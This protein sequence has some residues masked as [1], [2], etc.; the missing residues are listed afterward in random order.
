MTAI[1]ALRLKGKT[2]FL[3]DWRMPLGHGRLTMSYWYTNSQMP[4]A[5]RTELVSIS[6]AMLFTVMTCPLQSPKF[7][8]ERYSLS[9][10]TRSKLGSYLN[11]PLVQ[12]LLQ[13][14]SSITI[15]MS[16][17]RQCGLVIAFIRR[18]ISCH[19]VALLLVTLPSTK[20]TLSCWR[21]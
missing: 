5:R 14:I 12:S 15:T 17:V 6:F 21:K 1:G 3:T 11:R 19:R 7:Y 9:F 4:T 13:I 20:T 10:S 8:F 16:L 18:H 2:F